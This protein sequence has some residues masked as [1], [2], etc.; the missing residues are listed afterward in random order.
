MKYNSSAPVKLLYGEDC[1]RRA[2][3]AGCICG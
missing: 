3:A 2:K 1:T